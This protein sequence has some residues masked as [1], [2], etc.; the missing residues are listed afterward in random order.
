MRA[1]K[2][3]AAALGGGILG[4]ALWVGVADATGRELGLVAWGVGALVGVLVR[5]AARE[6]VGAGPGGIAAVVAVLSVAGGKYAT[7]AYIVGKVVAA[8][9]EVVTPEGRWAALPTEERVRLTDARRAEQ[10]RDLAAALPGLRL[11]A[12]KASFTPFDILWFGLA[13][14]TAARIGSGRSRAVSEN[15]RY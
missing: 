12:F 10:K 6:W 15:Y 4:V 9:A 8:E 3:V 1:L 2:V 11:A 5:A 13:V 7:V 14:L